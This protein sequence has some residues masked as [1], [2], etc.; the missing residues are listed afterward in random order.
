MKRSTRK[1]ARIG[2]A[3]LAVSLAALALA[4]PT[5]GLSEEGGQGP[6]A[7]GTIKSFDPETGE[8][9]V[10]LAKGGTIS[11]LV[12]RRTRIRCGKGRRHHR[13]G[14]RHRRRQGASVSLRG[15]REI[16]DDRRAGDA[17]SDVRGDRGIEP[18]DDRGGQGGEPSGDAHGHG[19]GHH[20]DRCNTGDL[21]PG[22][23]VMRAEMVLTHGNA[24]FKEIGL[25]PPQLTTPPEATNSE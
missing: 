6:R 11:G 8:L 2:G 22:A 23:V 24:F 18:G 20:G 4:L 17:P 16:G 7:A 19:H 13:R 25:L 3:L 9:V 10:D 12:V 21:V 14:R 5:I 1:R 15:V